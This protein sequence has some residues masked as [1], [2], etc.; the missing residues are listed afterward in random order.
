LES[1]DERREERE[2][3]RVERR[4]ERGEFQIFQKLENVKERES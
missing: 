2:E 4:D 1:R 3:E